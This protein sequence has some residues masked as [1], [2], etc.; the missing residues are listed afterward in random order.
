MGR[1]TRLVGLTALAGLVI[2]PIAAAITKQRLM[3]QGDEDS[4]EVE[5]VSIFEGRR[6][7]SQARGFT[8]GSLLAWYSGFDLDLRG[9]AIDPAGATL[10]VTS[11]FSGV[12]IRVPVDWR[13]RME[14]QLNILSGVDIDGPRTGSGPELTIEARALFSGIQVEVGSSDDDALIPPPPAPDLSLAEAEAASLASAE[15]AAEAPMS[16]EAAPAAEPVAGEQVAEA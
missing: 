10:R 16:A 13:V 12:Q 14:G 9:V 1:I 2:P 4:T 5:L 7:A 15:A 8:G 11:L 3:S 6:F